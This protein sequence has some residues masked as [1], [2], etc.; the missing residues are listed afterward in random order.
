MDGRDFL[1]WQRTTPGPDDSVG[2]LAVHDDGLLLPAVRIENLGVALEVE[3][4]FEIR[5][6]D[7]EVKAWDWEVKVDPSDPSVDPTNPN[8]EWPIG[9]IPEVQDNGLLLPY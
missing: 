4:D 5:G 3:S 2:S 1:I 8:V 7:R 9:P 6:S